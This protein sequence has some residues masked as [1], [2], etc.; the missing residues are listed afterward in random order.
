MQ[1]KD[2]LNTLEQGVKNV[3]N[4]ER[5]LKYL[6]FLSKFHNYSWRNTVLIFSQRPEAT[7]VAGFNDWK[8]KHN[9]YVKKGEKAIRIIAPYYKKFQAEVDVLDNNGNAVIVNGKHLTEKKE[10][11][12][13]LFRA[14]SVF[15]VSQTDGEPLPQLTYELQDTV[16]NYQELFT[17]ISSFSEYPIEFEDISGGAKG[18]FNFF[19]QRIAINNGMSESQ[20]IKTA[21]HELTHSRLHNP[22]IGS[23]KQNKTSRANEEVQA[24]SVAFVV[25][26]HFGIDTSDYSFDYIAGWSSGKELEELHESLEIIQKEANIIIQGIEEQY[27]QLLKD[28]SVEINNADKGVDRD[29]DGIEDSRDSSYTAPQEDITLQIADL[30]AKIAT[31]EKYNNEYAMAIAYSEDTHHAD[32]MR[33]Q[34]AKYEKEVLDMK[35][36]LNDLKERSLNKADEI[37]A[38]K[39]DKSVESNE[40]SFVEQEKVKLYSDY[41]LNND[42]IRQANAATLM[43]MGDIM[44][45]EYNRNLDLISQLN[46][47]IHN[48]NEV[49]KTLQNLYNQ[50]LSAQSKAVNPYVSG[51]A[52]PS[53]EQTN[54]AHTELVSK[55]NSDIQMFVSSLQSQSNKNNI[56]DRNKRVLS[57]M[58][59]A[60]KQ[61]LKS[62]TIDGTTYYKSRKNW[63]TEPP[64]NFKRQ[65]YS[66]EENTRIISD[67]KQSIPIHEYAQ[68]IGFTVQRVGNYYT[69][70]EHDSVRINPQKN[71]FT[72]NSTGVKGSIIDFVMHFEN[73]DKAAAIDKL[74]KHINADIKHSSNLN[75]N[76]PQYSAEKTYKDK[77]PL[78][79]PDKAKTMKNVFAYLINTRKIDSQIVSQWVKNKNLFQDTHNN[80]V[81]VTFDKSGKANFASQKG[82]N[83]SKP[84][85]ADIKGSDYNCCHFIN[86][87]AKSLIVCEAVIDLMS[88]Q[89]ILKANGRDLNNYNYLS[90]N[91]VSKTHAILNALQNSNTDTV[92]LATDNDRAGEQARSE[93]RELASKFDKNI[94]FVDYVPKSEK[95]WNAEL[96]S[97]VQRETT[98][99]SQ[100]NSK[101]KLSD[102]IVDC[103]NKAN[104]HNKMIDNNKSQS[105]AQKRNVPDL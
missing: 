90:L 3:F 105:L 33:E 103:Q 26:N 44:L 46:I 75:Q 8:N 79:L 31:A 96:V 18:Y 53:S 98:A 93:L 68:Q 16:K 22:N 1:S 52:R 27:K 23:D 76:N 92:I 2:I 86:N 7:L 12:K 50:Q 25:A 13:M 91:G 95:D 88:V 82:T 43:D 87:N 101:Q 63:S 71:V 20:T 47:D 104:E 102:K 94:K 45:R 15:D 6:T 42:L 81:F 73:L 61:G 77:E 85:Q 28:R 70:K 57:V 56:E 59:E 64:K 37:S 72:Q 97:N 54:K 74:A 84:F 62:V 40:K 60:E 29:M 55:I 48:K 78:I 34:L 24:E 39:S 58:S 5:Y 10:I 99:L 38:E 89:T 35:T 41:P 11:E 49:Y 65:D 66:K 19:D 69:L 36:T 32:L 14:V 9:R 80:C 30:E 17:A 51:V 100:S 21:I 67:I 4:S 83:T